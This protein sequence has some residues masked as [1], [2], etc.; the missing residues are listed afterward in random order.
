MVYERNSSV[1]TGS[2]RMA[3]FDVC[4]PGS[5]SGH[6]VISEKSKIR[7]QSCP[8]IKTMIRKRLLC[9]SRVK[10]AL[11]TGHCHGDDFPAALIFGEATP[12]EYR[13]PIGD[14]L[15]SQIVPM[16]WSTEG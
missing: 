9:A 12:A 5:V 3:A 14:I 6:G 10:Y 4:L 2:A 13:R 15:V 7:I 8:K 1:L 11:D 16:E